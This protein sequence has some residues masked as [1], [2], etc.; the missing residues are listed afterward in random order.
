[1]QKQLPYDVKRP[2]GTTSEHASDEDGHKCFGDLI[3][4]MLF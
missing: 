4:A 1:V 2:S 3:A